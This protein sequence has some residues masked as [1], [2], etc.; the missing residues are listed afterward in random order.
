MITRRNLTWL[1]PLLLFVSYPLWRAPVAAFLTPRGEYDPSLANRKL[2][3]HNFDLKN[4]RIT[5]SENG[6][7]TLEIT[8]KRAYT[9]QKKDEFLLD[10]VDAVIIAQDKE[11]TFVSARRGV[12]DKPQAILTLIDEVVVMKPKEKFELY[13]DLLIY[14]ENTHIAVSPGRTQVL[15]EKIDITGNGLTFNT[16]TSAYDLGGRVRC[17]LTNFSKP[18]PTPAAN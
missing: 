8:A 1:I 16:L 17:K 12:L 18:A 14:N 5:Q 15:G 4:V 3:S 10:E 13:T 7:T 6:Q 2:D 11:Q 9:G